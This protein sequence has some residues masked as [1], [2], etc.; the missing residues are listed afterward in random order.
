[1]TS[2]ANRTAAR[3]RLSGAAASAAASFRARCVLTHGCPVV[4]V[5]RSFG[6]ARHIGQRT[7][8]MRRK[9]SFSVV[10]FIILQRCQSENWS[11]VLV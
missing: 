8:K 2:L 6:L 11:I 3:P 10:T 4:R 5:H 7:D 9:L 1:V